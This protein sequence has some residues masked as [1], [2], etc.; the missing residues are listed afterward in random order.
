MKIEDILNGLPSKEELANALS[1]Q[2]RNTGGDLRPALGIFGAGMLLGAGL[3]FLFAPTSGQQSRHE[4][5]SGVGHKLAEG[6]KASTD[7]S[8]VPAA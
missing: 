6:D 3:A 1:G 4:R 8:D 7:G 2:T 5:V